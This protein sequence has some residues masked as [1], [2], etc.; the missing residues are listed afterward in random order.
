ML[1]P[2]YSFAAMG[3]GVQ[4]VIVHK[5]IIAWQRSKWHKE[6]AVGKY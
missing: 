5:S 3:M 4:A 1:Y 6:K 2:A